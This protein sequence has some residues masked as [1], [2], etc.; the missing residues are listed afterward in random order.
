MPDLVLDK[1]P[2]DVWSYS[3]RTITRP[4]QYLTIGKAFIP[5]IGVVDTGL[6]IVPRASYIEISIPSGEAW[7]LYL[8][9]RE[10]VAIPYMF[11]YDGVN[12]SSL[13]IIP[14]AATFFTGYI[15]FRGGWTLRMRNPDTA[16]TYAFRALFF[17]LDSSVCTVIGGLYNI[18]GDTTSTV[19]TRPS[20][21]DKYRVFMYGQTRGDGTNSGDI[22][23]MGAS[24]GTYGGAP[25]I[26][27]A[28]GT[29]TVQWVGARD[30]W[31]AVA[32]RNEYASA[33]IFAALGLEVKL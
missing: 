32:I 6:R 31:N 5:V 26:T 1:T 3:P 19:I 27:L 8:Y 11:L 10:H 4:P 30:D 22:R 13:D 12:E 29:G 21:D 9:M 25:Y 24:G 33:Q 20:I 15:P 7:L 14:G 17:K 18:P 28:S 16:L 23:L 2:K